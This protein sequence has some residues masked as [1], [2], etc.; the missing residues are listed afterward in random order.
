MASIAPDNSMK[1]YYKNRRIDLETALLLAEALQRDLVD[2]EGSQPGGRF[3]GARKAARK[4]CEKIGIDL[5][6][7][8]TRRQL[9]RKIAGR[10]ARLKEKVLGKGSE[11]E[12]FW[13][14]H[15]YK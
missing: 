8:A 9:R 2:P 12:A 15:E 4:A 5:P 6:T 11:Y 3:E 1:S 10:L 13:E 7:L 14:A